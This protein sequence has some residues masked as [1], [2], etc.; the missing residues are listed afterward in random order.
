MAP[1]IT[2]NVGE[3][4]TVIVNMIDQVWEGLNYVIIDVV[5]AY[6]NGDLTTDPDYA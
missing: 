2:E 1:F 4:G 3:Q 6:L 5:L